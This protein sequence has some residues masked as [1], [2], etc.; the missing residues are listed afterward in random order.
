MHSAKFTE[1]EKDG[2]TFHPIE[3]IGPLIVES[4]EGLESGFMTFGVATTVGS[5]MT[6]A[7]IGR[8]VKD[9]I[10]FMVAHDG[11][12]FSGI[13]HGADEVEHFANLRA[14]VDVVAQEDHLAPFRVTVIVFVGEVSQR[15]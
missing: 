3:P 4:G 14:T 1:V 2:K 6:S 9:R 13:H 12:C 15:V 8:V 5:Q 10:E 7:A 11:E